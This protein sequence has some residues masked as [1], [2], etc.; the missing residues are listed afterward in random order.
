MGSGRGEETQAELVRRLA[1]K[2]IRGTRARAN[3]RGGISP[4]SYRDG[5]FVFGGAVLR[6]VA[7]TIETREFGEERQMAMGLRKE[8]K[9]AI[10]RNRAENGSDTNEQNRHLHNAGL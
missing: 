3:K 2:A 5:D 4:D 1:E 10:N 9:A 6:E 7:F 8:I